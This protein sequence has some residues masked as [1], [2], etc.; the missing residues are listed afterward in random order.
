[1]DRLE[2]RNRSRT[3]KA[4]LAGDIPLLRQAE[5]DC[6]YCGEPLA[7]TVDCSAGNQSYFE[8]C[9]VCCRPI[10]LRCEVDDDGNLL[11]VTAAREDD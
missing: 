9:E 6:P 4:F 11:G 7:M 1:M 2:K 10:L 3:G 8:D 5:I